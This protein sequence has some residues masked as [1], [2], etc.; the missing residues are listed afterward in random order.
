MSIRTLT[1]RIHSMLEAPKISTDL[2]WELVLLFAGL[3]GIYLILIFRMRNRISARR[4]AIRLQK[5]ELAPMISN[6]L[7]YQHESED[8]D[9]ETYIRMKIEIRELL[10][11][12]L[13]REVMTEILVDRRM[14]VSGEPRE[15]LFQVFQDLNLDRDSFR[16]LESWR[17]ER[18]SQGIMELTEMHVEKA[19]PFIRKFVNDRRGVIRKQA[20]LAT[21]MLREEGIAYF[22]DTARYRISEWQQLKLLEILRQREDFNPPRFRAWLTSE[23]RDVV[24]FALRL[25]RYYRQN[26]AE[27]ALVTLLRHRNQ[28]VRAAALEC[29]REFRFHS[30][31]EP[32]KALF[33]NSNEE[34]KLLI[35][36]TLGLIASEAELH[37]LESVASRDGNFVVRSKARA[38]M[39]QLKPDS[40]LPLVGP[41]TAPEFETGTVEDPAK[42]TGH[43]TSGKTGE[44][45]E[46]NQAGEE[47]P[48]LFWEPMTPDTDEGISSVPGVTPSFERDV[49]R[50]PKAGPTEPDWEEDEAVFDACFLEELEDILS[51]L[52]GAPEHEG[53]LPLDF[54]PLVTEPSVQAEVD[55]C[56]IQ[57]LEVVAEWVAPHAGGNRFSPPAEPEAGPSGDRLN[58]EF[59]PWVVPGPDLPEPPD[60]KPSTEPTMSNPAN[61]HPE[62]FS[63]FWE[64]LF[65]LDGVSQP[66]ALSGPENY[67]HEPAGPEE[68]GSGR[69]SIF[70]EF[71]REY[72]TESRLLLLEHIA[73]VG[74]EKEWEFLCELQEDPEPMI[75]AKALQMVKI[76][77]SKLGL[78]TTP[79]Q[80]A[81][82][83]PSPGDH[84]TDK[85]GME[86]NFTPES[87]LAPHPATGEENRHSHRPAGRWGRWTLKRKKQSHG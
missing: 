77:G 13:N 17:W 62:G 6:F 42:V 82:P 24:L 73:V 48:E 83:S 66:A 12:P 36:D 30:A 78:E 61:S 3:G 68:E 53:V 29:I 39:N 18:V 37:F 41:N 57:E 9:R 26:D 71:F 7:F 28:V 1:Y 72:D 35:L 8:E 27:L 85:P 5:R 58:T 75:R 20:Q 16:R 34:L 52:K 69:F 33:P 47:E 70:R 31:L 21:V 38:V 54:L 46:V 19:Y 63:Y 25:I 65:E 2:L 15:R 55:P 45:A 79:G 51:E 32:M 44:P 86:L 87:A 4:E 59:L 67:F 74:E 11:A 43:A 81:L 22:L 60:V 64:P 49:I 56:T 50:T 23:N 80:E 14:D 84:P 10:K 76:L 40:A